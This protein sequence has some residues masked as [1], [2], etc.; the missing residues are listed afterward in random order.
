MR[1]KAP[2][3]GIIVDELKRH[4]LWILTRTI[5]AAYFTTPGRVVGER[6]LKRDV[7]ARHALWASIYAMGR[8]SL[9]ELGRMFGRDHTTILVGIRKHNA[10]IGELAA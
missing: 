8:Y 7:H 10:R 6:R 1:P 2:P 5:A 9:P 3:N 4:R